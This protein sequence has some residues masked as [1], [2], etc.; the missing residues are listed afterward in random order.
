MSLSP[1]AACSLRARSE[2]MSEPS[3][4]SAR[5]AG[6]GMPRPRIFWLGIAA[7]TLGV[8]GHVRM[9]AAAGDTHYMLHGMGIDVEMVVGMVAIAVGLVLTVIGLLPR[10]R[11]GATRI[12]SVDVS[13]EDGKVGLAHAS[14]L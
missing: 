7:I 10:T 5:T 13:V 8:L 2:P 12:P 9:F 14:L 4:I 6:V 3:S 1:S 11:T